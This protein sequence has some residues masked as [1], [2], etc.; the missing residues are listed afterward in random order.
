M[1]LYTALSDVPAGYGPSVVTIGNFD[2]VHRGHARVISRVVS[3]AEEH[4]LR[5][6]AVSFDPHPIQVHRPEVA[7][8]DIMSQGARRHYMCLLGLDDYLLMHYSLEFAQQTP[9]EFV[10]TTFVDGLNARY[11]VIGDDVRFGRNNSGDLNT[12]RELGEKY[13]FEVVVVEDLMVDENTRCSSTRIRQLLLEGNMPAATE[14]LGRHHMM[15]GEVVHGLARGRELGFP[16]ANLDF[17]ARGLL[18]ADGV[19]AGWLVD[20]VGTRHPS[21]ISVGTN[22][23]FDGIEHRQVEAH[24]IDRPKERVEDFNLYGQHVLIE[25]VKRLRPM[26]AYTGVEALIDQINDDVV[27]TREVLAEDAKTYRPPERSVRGEKDS[28]TKDSEAENPE[29]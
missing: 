18:P 21:A 12:M 9:E 3:L 1:T 5:S 16:T 15:A 13:G 14:L 23:T 2:G 17:E 4:G 8:H 6:I 22:P 20:E 7:H 26:V 29:A 25:F 11:V 10:K 27:K 24:V 19:Y 28:E